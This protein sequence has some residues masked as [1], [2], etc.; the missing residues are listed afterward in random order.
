MGKVLGDPLTPGYASLADEGRRE[1]VEDNPGLNRI[2]SIPLSWSD[3]RNLL[4]ALEGQGKHLDEDWGKGAV[5]DVDWWTGNHSPIVQLQNDQ[6]EVERAPIYNVLGRIVG[7]EQPN[8][9]IIVGNHHD[10]WC[11]GAGDPGSGTAVFLEVIRIF[12][13]LREL[14]WRPLRTIEF[15]SW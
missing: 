1:S 3:A 2:P 4:R 14:G 7:I 5:P 13:E 8:L 15:A 11:L 6:D 10:A 9:S 12:G